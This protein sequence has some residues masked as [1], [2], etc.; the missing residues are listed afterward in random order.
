MQNSTQLTL[1]REDAFAIFNLA[2][3]A[4]FA[5]QNFVEI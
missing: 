4:T 2:I 1:I 5:F 3:K